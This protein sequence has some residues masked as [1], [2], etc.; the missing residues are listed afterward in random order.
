ML[1]SEMLIETMNF[2]DDTLVTNRVKYWQEVKE[3][4]EEI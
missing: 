1:V 4:I 3:I 2:C